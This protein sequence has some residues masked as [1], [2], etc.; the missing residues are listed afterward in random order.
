MRG[1]DSLSRDPDGISLNL[2]GTVLKTV[3]SHKVGGEG[4]VVAAA[5]VQL[6]ARIA[7]R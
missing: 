3:P 1:D 2:V 6:H 7:S 5:R 4:L